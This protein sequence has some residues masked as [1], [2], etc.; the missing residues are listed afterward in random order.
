M[1]DTIKA[2]LRE[3][4]RHDD[5]WVQ[6]I[7][8]DFTEELCRR[9]D[10]LGIS[11]KALADRIQKSPPYVTKVLRGDQNLTAKSMARLARAVQ[12]VVRVHLAPAEAYT[13]WLDVGE[14]DVRQSR[15]AANLE[16]VVFPGEHGTA[17]QMSLHSAM[18]ATGI[19]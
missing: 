3:A 13:V 4:R 2:M 8:S 11:R 15:P 17:V 16:D 18:S 14:A 5:Y 12:S 6:W 9:M 1:A 10:V 7:V 19:S